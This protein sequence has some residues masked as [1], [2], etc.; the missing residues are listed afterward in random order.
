MV[1]D[2]FHPTVKMVEDYFQLINWLKIFVF[3]KMSQTL[4]YK[5]EELP[6]IFLEKSLND[7]INIET[8]RKNKI[9]KNGF[10]DIELGKY[11]FKE[12]YKITGP[13]ESVNKFLEEN[14]LIENT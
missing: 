11:G 14:G 5:G 4:K 2:Y 6:Q 9:G 8:G 7:Y 13:R 12:N 10:L 1:E 3:Q